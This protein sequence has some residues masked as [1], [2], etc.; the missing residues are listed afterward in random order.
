MAW[1]MSLRPL[2][3]DSHTARTAVGRNRDGDLAGGAGSAGEEEER[4]RAPAMDMPPSF[5]QADMEKFEKKFVNAR[6]DR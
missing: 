2:Q 5:Y 1:I 4:A 3:P 6:N